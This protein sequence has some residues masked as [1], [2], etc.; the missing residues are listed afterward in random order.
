MA[1]NPL[2]GK[3]ILAV[4]DEEDVLELIA[5]ELE[6]YGVKIDMASTFDEGYEKIAADTHDAAILDIM[7]VRGFELLQFASSR[8]MPVIIL[9]AHALSADSLRKSIDLGARAFLPKDQL[10]TLAPFVQDVLTL[11]YQSAWKSV[12]DKVRASLG[13]RFGSE[14][15]KTEKEF[16]EKFDQ[17][18]G[19]KES[20]IIEP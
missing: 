20:V 11:N 17:E 2:K 12:F 13:K 7:G 5:E 19:L 10:G 8:K 4:D 1:E 6:E 9:T 3:H 16:W 18:I 14:W 15:R